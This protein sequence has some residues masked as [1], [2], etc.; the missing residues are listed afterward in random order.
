MLALLSGGGRAPRPEPR[1]GTSTPWRYLRRRNG[2]WLPLPRM[3]IPVFCVQLCDVTMLVA[4]GSAGCIPRRLL[5]VR[6]VELLWMCAP[7]A[8]AHQG[9]LVQAPAARYAVQSPLR[10]GVKHAQ[11]LQVRTLHPDC[12]DCSHCN[13]KSGPFDP[14]VLTSILL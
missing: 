7:R 2:C 4:A 3:H 5:A 9:P 6:V 11:C 8:A 14:D 13:Q 10:R 12:S 1:P